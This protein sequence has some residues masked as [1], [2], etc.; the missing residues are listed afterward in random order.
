MWAYPTIRHV[1]SGR[2]RFAA[3]PPHRATRQPS[4]ITVQVES[5]EGRTWADEP[6][7]HRHRERIG[8]LAEAGATWFVV[9]P[10]ADDAEKGLDA[11]RRYGTEVIEA[12]AP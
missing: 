10:P 8:E 9:D 6:V 3:E 1:G 5:S 7:L 12:V 11:L 2:H 4:E